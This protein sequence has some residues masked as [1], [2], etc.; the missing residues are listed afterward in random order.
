MTERRLERAEIPM[1]VDCGYELATQRNEDWSPRF[2]CGACGYDGDS[3]Y[4][5]IYI[6]PA[7]DVGEVVK[8]LRDCRDMLQ[9]EHG[10]PTVVSYELHKLADELE[11]SHD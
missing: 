7:V 11:K 5:G 4:W 2:L 9:K 8:R 1:C 10:G 6:P 3:A